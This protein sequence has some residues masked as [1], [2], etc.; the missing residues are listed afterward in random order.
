MSKFFN[1]NEVNWPNVEKK[2]IETDKKIVVIQINGKKKSNWNS[3]RVIRKKC[4]W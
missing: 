1:L 2:F 4:D 3:D